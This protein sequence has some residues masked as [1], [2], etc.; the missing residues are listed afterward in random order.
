MKQVDLASPVPRDSAVPYSEFKYRISEEIF[1]PEP[2]IVI[3]IP[4]SDVLSAR[5]SR[6]TFKVIS[7]EK[8]NALLWHSARAITIT[9]PIHG[10]R[11]QHR[12][13][14]SAGGRHPIDILII[15]ERRDSQDV[16]LYDPVAHKLCKLVVKET[17]SLD[18]LVNLVNRVIPPEQATI[19]LFGAQF[20]RT[21]SVYKYGESLV[22]R[23]AGALIATLSLVA[24]SLELNCCALGITGEPFLSQIVN[25]KGKVL[26]VGGL[27]IGER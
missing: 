5:R 13:S 4:F 22:W 9:P 26:G 18:E 12:P 6:R 8:L 21:L 7:A 24:E 27:L 16:F 25:S 20:E 1:L 15:G 17:S 10:A 23:D 14:P 19:I 3:E 2:E 11:W